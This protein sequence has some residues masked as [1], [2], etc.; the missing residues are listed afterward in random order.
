MKIISGGIDRIISSVSHLQVRILVSV[1]LLSDGVVVS[2]VCGDGGATVG[3][4]ATHSA[5]VGAL[6]PLVVLHRTHVI[7]CRGWSSLQS[8]LRHHTSSLNIIFII[9]TSSL[10]IIFFII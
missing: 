7:L 10:R 8:D 9:I 6:V 3:L 4:F 5:L 1:L 2:N